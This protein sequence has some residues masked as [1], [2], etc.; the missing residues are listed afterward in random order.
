M[1]RIPL[2]RY[3]NAI[4]FNSERQFQI[5]GIYLSVVVDVEDDASGCLTITGKCGDEISVVE[6]SAP[7]PNS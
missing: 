6:R 7:P 2:R 1:I 3:A 4:R 5:T